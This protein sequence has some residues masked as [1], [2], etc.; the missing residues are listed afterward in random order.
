MFESLLSKQ[1]LCEISGNDWK[2]IFYFFLHPAA[3][4]KNEWR[5]LQCHFEL[6]EQRLQYKDSINRTTIS[7]ILEISKES[8]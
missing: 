7:D 5:E 6:R 4:D 3:Q 1:R 8:R 2:G